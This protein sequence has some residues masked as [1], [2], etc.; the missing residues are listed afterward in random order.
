MKTLIV[1]ALAGAALTLAAKYFK[2]T[3]FEQVKDLIPQ[4]KKV[5]PNMKQMM[6]HN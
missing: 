1:L 6:T 3:S 5:V 4:L 2:I